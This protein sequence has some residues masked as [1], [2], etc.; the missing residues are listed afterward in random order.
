MVV[1]S[2]ARAMAR[3]SFG[4]M[5]G[6]RPSETYARLGRGQG[7]R[8]GANVHYRFR[9]LTRTGTYV[10]LCSDMVSSAMAESE[11]VGRMPRADARRSRER[12]LAAAGPLLEDNPR[13]TMA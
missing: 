8:G 10:S 6:N 3:A 13:A 1:P 4:S 5:G 7:R 12:I 9:L 2:Y 11:E